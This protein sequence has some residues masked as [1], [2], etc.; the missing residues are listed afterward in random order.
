MHLSSSTAGLIIWSDEIG[1]LSEGSDL[2]SVDGGWDGDPELYERFQLLSADFSL[3]ENS[4]VVFALR[5][6]QHDN[7]R[8]DD[9]TTSYQ[10]YTRDLTTQQVTKHS[11]ELDGEFIASESLQIP[12]DQSLVGS[13]LRAVITTTDSL[14]G[15]STFYPT[16]SPFKTL[17][18][19]QLDPSPSTV[20][21]LRTKPS[22]PP[23]PS[24]IKTA[25]V[26]SPTPGYAMATPLQQA[27]PTHSRKTMSAHP[28]P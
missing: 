24:R 3:P 20:N 8:A 12:D 15:S 18:T 4:Q 19:L 7:D 16:H 28:L 9:I 25:L 14:G 1:T 26:P 23:T 6:T 27:P 10:L 11:F 13:T 21:S 22:L 17:M 2:R 5:T